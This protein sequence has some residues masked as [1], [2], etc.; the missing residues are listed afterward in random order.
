MYKFLGVHF[1]YWL[2]FLWPLAF[3]LRIKIFPTSFTKD[4]LQKKIDNRSVVYIISKMSIVD[5]FVLN[6]ALKILKQ[7]TIKTEVT[8]R[9]AWRSAVLA[10]KGRHFF[11]NVSDRDRQVFV[12]KI[13]DLIKENS[14]KKQPKFLFLPVGIYWSRAAERNEKGFLLRS[15]FPDDGTGNFLQKLFMLL[16]HRGEISVSFGKEIEIYLPT[17]D[18]TQKTD[19]L[20]YQSPNLD[21]IY[22]RRLQ[23]QFL[24]EF[25]KERTAFL[26]PVLYEKDKITQWILS[27]EQTKKYLMDSEHPEKTKHQIERY[28]N[29]IS[30]NYSYATLRAVEQVFD[31]LWTKVFTGIR[32]RN[33][34]KIERLIKDNCVIWMPCHR[35]HFDY[36]LLN[37]LL[38]KHGSIAPHVAAGINLNF[39][40]IG[41]FLRSGG[42]FFIRRSFSGNRTYTHTFSEY[43]N[44]LLHNSYPI[45]FFPEGGRSRIG[46]LVSPKLGMLSICVQSVMSRKAEN[47]Y[48]M[49][50]SINYDKV[51]EDNTY[52]RELRGAKKQKENVLQFLNGVRK[53]FANYGSLD[54][55]FGEPILISQ[56]W[57]DYIKRYETKTGQPFTLPQFKDLPDDIDTRDPR[58][59][60][61]IKY[62]AYRV[63]EK[64]NCAATASTTALLSTVLLALKNQKFSEDT[65]RLYIL[66]LHYTVNDLAK[67]LNWQIATSKSVSNVFDYIQMYME[68]GNSHFFVNDSLEKFSQVLQFNEEF[69]KIGKRWELIKEFSESDKIFYQKNPDKEFNLWWYRGTVFHIFA[70]VGVLA[71]VLISCER[72]QISSLELIFENL[73]NL[74][75]KELFW[76][77]NTSTKDLIESGLHVLSNFNVLSYDGLHIK[78]DKAKFAHETVADVSPKNILIFFSNIIH[79]EIELYGLLLATGLFLMSKKRYFDRQELLEKAFVTH[80][81]AH[82]QQYTTNASTFVKV[83]GSTTFDNIVRRN[84]FVNI[85]RNRF[86]VDILLIGGLSEFFNLDK[87]KNFF[88]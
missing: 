4:V 48:L 61:F 10:L 67:Q 12:H 14:G 19:A 72:Y 3:L 23:R 71:K 6:R 88:A 68:S 20:K 54:V 46:K 77:I 79:L 41:P 29:E 24:I 55:S 47:T 60:S 59:Q 17:S 80:E 27:S 64:I 33:Y 5:I 34:E 31:F 51:M 45:E 75:K 38:F 30:A 44:F 58:I 16:L 15:L 53:V 32:V 8:L 78:F 84:I 26:G 63:H 1:R 85:E 36:L 65:L 69:L 57:T 9:Y 40:P 62:L 81:L 25:A 11:S 28:I 56:A 70:I 21:L 43:V 76:D 73:R 52:A 49:P 86:T 39:W 50:V 66:V 87:W 35:S 2:K 7:P 74:W 82:K 37:Y 22:A 42:A 13:V 18:S 83:F